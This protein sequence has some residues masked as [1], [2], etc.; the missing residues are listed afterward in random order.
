MR[1]RKPVTVAGSIGET[2]LHAPTALLYH[3]KIIQFHN[4]QNNRALML[5]PLLF[6]SYEIYLQSSKTFQVSLNW[7]EK[8]SCQKPTK[9]GQFLFYEAVKN[10]LENS[11]ETSFNNTI[12]TCRKPFDQPRDST[13]REERA[14]FR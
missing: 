7:I 12:S 9:Y 6:T 2:L 5:T 11:K 13:A 4:E 1:C 14:A 10:A 3:W 8:F